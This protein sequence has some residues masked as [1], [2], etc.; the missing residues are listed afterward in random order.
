MRGVEAPFQLMVSV[1][2][3]VL[4]MIIAYQVLQNAQQKR[5]GDMWREQLRDVALVIKHVSAA[6]PPTQESTTFRA[7]C[8]GGERH[9]IKLEVKKDPNFC[10]IICNSAVDQCYILR[11]AVKRTVGGKEQLVASIAV[12]ADISPVAYYELGKRGSCPAGAEEVGK[13]LKGDGIVLDKFQYTFLIRR[14]EDGVAVCV[15]PPPG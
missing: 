2:A 4:I 7:A 8:A 12:C 14:T 5:C 9:T 6:A 15:T 3:M 10:M 11:D 1:F 13:E